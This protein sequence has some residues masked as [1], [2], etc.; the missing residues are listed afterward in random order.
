[1]TNNYTP[2]NVETLILVAVWESPFVFQ[3]SFKII[4]K[5]RHTERFIFY[6]CECNKFAK[7]DILEEEFSPYDYQFTHLYRVA[8]D[9]SQIEFMGQLIDD[10]LYLLKYALYTSLTQMI[11]SSK[12]YFTYIDEVALLAISKKIGGVLQEGLDIQEDQELGFA[13]SMDFNPS[14]PLGQAAASA[15]LV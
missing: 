12:Q 7:T 4:D 13:V 6:R 2:I 10:A 9:H 15:L 1:M 11:R 8:S 3:G 5:S 14:E